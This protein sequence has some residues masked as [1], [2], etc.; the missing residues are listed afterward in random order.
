[1]NTSSFFGERPLSFK[2]SLAVAVGLNGAIFI[3][4]LHFVIND[5]VT[6]Q[7]ENP[8]WVR[9]TREEWRAHHFP[10]WSRDV[11]RHTIDK[12]IDKG[13]ISMTRE[14]NHNPSDSTYWYTINYD[15][16]K[17]LDEIQSKEY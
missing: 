17:E 7:E 1:M 15:A 2:P 6:T 3:Q 11:L 14:F 13:L 8:Y 9:R 12:L 5:Q 10:F 4:E 16:L